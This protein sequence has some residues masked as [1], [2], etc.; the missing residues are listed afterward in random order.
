MITLVQNNAMRLNALEIKPKH[1]KGI[2]TKL[3]LLGVLH[4]IKASK[5]IEFHGDLPKSFR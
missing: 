3:V 5:N 1:L 2:W 4:R